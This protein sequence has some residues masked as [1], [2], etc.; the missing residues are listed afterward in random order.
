MSIFK[1][2]PIHTEPKDTDKPLL[3]ALF[4]HD[5]KMLE[6][7]YNTAWKNV[8]SEMYWVCDLSWDE[9]PTHWAYQPDGFSQIAEADD[10]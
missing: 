3:I 6:F 10:E 2:E 9:Q 1:W 7:G 5:G 8:R 4:N